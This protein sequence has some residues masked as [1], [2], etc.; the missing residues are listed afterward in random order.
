M[1][2]S[3]GSNKGEE[4]GRGDEARQSGA[5]KST[6]T[7]IEE[8]ENRY[9]APGMSLSHKNT[10]V[11]F[12]RHDFVSDFWSY[13]L[14]GHSGEGK[15]PMYGDF[16]AQRHWMEITVRRPCVCCVYY[17]IKKSV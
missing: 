17:R 3:K 5:R 14:H 15:P 4:V 10:L 12:G 16:E 13:W 8:K 11:N 7:R 2:E 9:A 1:V 6:G